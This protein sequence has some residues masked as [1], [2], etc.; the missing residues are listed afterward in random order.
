MVAAGKGRDRNRT[1]LYRK[2]GGVSGAKIGP[3]LLFYGQRKTQNK[4]PWRMHG[5]H[6]HLHWI[7]WLGNKEVGYHEGLPV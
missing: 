6:G 7:T 3:C 5:F 1:N 2:L 4:N